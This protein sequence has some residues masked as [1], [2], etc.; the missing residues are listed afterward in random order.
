MKNYFRFLAIVAIV[1][2]SSCSQENPVESNPKIINISILASANNITKASYTP[3]DALAQFD[4]AWSEGDKVSVIVDGV[5]GNENQ[6]FTAATSTT[7]TALDGQVVAWEGLKNVYA[8]YP[9]SSSYFTQSNDDDMLLFFSCGSQVVDVSASNTFENGL[10]VCS[11]PYASATDEENY[12]IPDL[13]FQQ[14]MAFYQ[15]EISG[16]AEGETITEIGLNSGESAF[17]SS[18]NISL[19]S[20]EVIAGSTT[21][22]SSIS[23]TVE[24]H[25][26]TSA[27]LNLALLP[28]DLSDSAVELYFET[29]TSGA[30]KTYTKSFENGVDFTR[31]TFVT[32]ENSLDAT[33]DFSVEIDGELTLADFSANSFPTA[34]TW[35]IVDQSATASDFAGLQAALKATTLTEVQI[36][37]PNLT[38]VPEKAFENM[39]R[40]VAID[41]P[42]VESVADNAFAS[43]TNLATVNMPKVLTM[44]AQAFYNCRALGDLPFELLTQ[45]GDGAF[46]DC[47]ALKTISLPAL[48]TIGTSAFSSCSLLTSASLPAATSIADNVFKY[49]SELTEL[50]LATLD[51]AVI[52]SLGSG[53]FTGFMGSN[54]ANITLTTGLQNLPL[55]SGYTLSLGEVSY[56]FKQIIVLDIDKDYVV[57]TAENAQIVVW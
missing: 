28:V 34:A 52:T 40:I 12:Y 4:F 47:Y 17:I 37:M 24:G 51:D 56:T 8:V 48:V 31:N 32:H 26:G 3:N 43:C 14:A 1:I 35:T 20:A 21:T 23:A 15:V 11:A 25:S 19:S 57:A 45:I 33:T 50:E 55:V 46:Y 54:S 27:T 38:A 39:S 7:S 29:T 22:T 42:L 10:L 2:C 49:S 41:A 44:G 16:L 18:A 5:T 30:T 9:Y 6:P 53:I 13:Y 36:A